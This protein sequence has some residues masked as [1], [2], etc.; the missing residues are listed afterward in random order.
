MVDVVSNPSEGQ[1][2][3]PTTGVEIGQFYYVKGPGAGASNVQNG[4]ILAV[5]TGFD[6]NGISPA[7]RY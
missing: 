2:A 3:L 4:N 1:T 5:V 7:E 6:A